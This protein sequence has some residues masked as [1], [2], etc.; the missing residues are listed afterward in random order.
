MMG[1]W[2]LHF[3]FV[4]YLCSYDV[5]TFHSEGLVSATA[6]L[7]HLHHKHLVGRD[8]E[9]VEHEYGTLI[10]VARNGCGIIVCTQWEDNLLL[11]GCTLHYLLIHNLEGHKV[12]LI[13]YIRCVLRLRMEVKQTIVSVK[14]TQQK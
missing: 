2:L 1:V 14:P 8:S 6:L 7:V 11:N 3:K 9:L 5:L 4:D 12:H 13:R 10:L